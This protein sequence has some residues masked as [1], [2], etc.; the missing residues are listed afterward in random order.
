MSKKV[1]QNWLWDEKYNVSAFKLGA[2]VDE[3]LLKGLI[4]KVPNI[5]GFKENDREEEYLP[6]MDDNLHSIT[7]YDNQIYLL[8]YK[9][10]D[11]FYPSLWN[12]E[13]NDFLMEID[14]YLAKTTDICPKK[15]YLHIVFVDSFVRTAML[16][17]GEILNK[18][19]EDNVL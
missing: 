1:K 2:K 11:F 3:L 13:Y 9:Q 15:D 8:T 6:V 16:I 14:K 10:L 18:L 7:T 12:K 19:R 5:Q 4:H 17:R